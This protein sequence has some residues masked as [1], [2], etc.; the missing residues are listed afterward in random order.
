[1]R[2]TAET[3]TETRRRILEA[4]RRLFADRGY[5]A[6]STRDL[7]EAAGS[8]NGPLFNYFPTKEAIVESLVTEAHAAATAKFA[9]ADRAEPGALEEQMF[10]HVAA[11]LR[12]LQPYRKYL[13]AVLETALSPLA[14][15][16]DGEAPSLRTAHLETV[17]QIVIRHGRQAALTPLALQL[18]W[19]LFTG[20]LAFWASDESHRQEDTL[21]LLDQSLTMFVG[22]LTGQG[23]PATEPRTGG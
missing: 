8:A 4:A 13:A 1:M 20:V 12:K 23:D 19:T 3:K 18:Y 22:W 10:A 6:S 14:A 17:V 11:V 7:A 2:V 9:G 15:R 16:L 5:E 21:A